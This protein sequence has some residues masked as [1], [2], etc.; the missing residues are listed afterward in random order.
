MTRKLSNELRALQESIA[1]AVKQARLAYSFCPGSYSHSAMNACLQAG[2][3]FRA[4]VDATLSPKP[5]ASTLPSGSSA[6]ERLRPEDQPRLSKA[7]FPTRWK[8][9]SG[10][11][12]AGGRWR[13]PQEKSGRV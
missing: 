3:N 13:Q 1:E 4:V 7:T 11:E 9:K 12:G 2:R 10:A 5:L 8:Q 6:R